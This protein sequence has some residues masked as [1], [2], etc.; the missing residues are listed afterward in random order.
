MAIKF[1]SNIRVGNF[2]FPTVDGTAGQVLGTDGNGNL[3]FMSAATAD[4]Y[5]NGLTFSSGTLTASVAGGSDV[6][7]SLDGRYALTSHNH[8]GVYDNYQFWNLK[9]NGTQ[10]TTVQSGG[11]LD[12]V[13]GSNVSLSYSAGGVVTISSTDTDTNYY[14]TSA[15]FNTS[16]GI[17]T[18]TRNDGGTVTVDL[19]GKY[20]ESS[21]THSN[22]TQS[23]AGFMSA[24][25]KT[26]LDGIAT[27]ATANTGTVTSVSGTGSVSG[28]TL[29]GTVTTSGSLTLGGT[30]V[31]TSGQVT[32]ALGYTPYQ[33]GTALDASTITLPQNP[34]G[35]T[36]GNGVASAPA[37]Y[38]GQAAGGDD[39]WKLY[40][41]SSAANSVSMVFEV[42]DDIEVAG[43][44]WIFRNKKTYGDYAATTPFRISGAGAA[45]INGNIVYHAGNFT[46]N[47]SNWN[48]AYS[49]GNHATAGYLTSVTNIS[50]NAGTATTLQTARSINGTAFNG[51]ADITTSFW[52]STRTITIGST[53]KSVNGSGNVSWTLAEIGAPSTTGTGASGTWPIS[54]SG[55]ADTVDGYHASS[56]WRSDGGTWNPTANIALNQTAN[57]QEWSFDIT[58]NGYTGGY[59][60]VWDSTN[61]TMLKVDAVTGKVSAPYN[62]VGNLEGNASTSTNAGYANSAGTAGSVTG[63]TLN[64]SGNPI[65]PDNVTQNQLGYNTNVSL[66]GQTDGGLYS[67]AYSSSWIH[68]IYGD[69]RSGQIAVR[70]KNNGSWQPWRTVLDSS[71]F[72]SWAQPAG[73][74]AAASHTHTPSQVGLGNVTNDTQV[75]VTYNTT[76][77]SDTR[78]RR[79]VTRLFR[80]DDDSDFSVQTYWTGSY[81]RLYGYYGDDGHADT[82]VGYADS[83]GYSS[84]TGS[85]A[86]TNVSGRPTNVS[87]FTNDS[88][89]VTAATNRWYDGWVTA[90]GY[91]ADT[92]AGSKSGFTYA[93]NAPYNGPLA[94]IEAGGYGLQL[95]ASYGGGG[96]QIGYRTRNGDAGTW[97]SWRELMHSGNIGSQSVN[98]ASSA[99]SVAWG[100]VSSKPS[101]L[102]YWDT[103]YGSSYLGSDGN[104]YMGWAGAWLSTWLNQSVRTDADP[105]FR[106]VY[107]TGWFRNY[108]QQGIYNQDYGTHFYSVG[109]GVWGITGSGSGVELQFRAN[110]QSTIRGYVYGDTSNNFGF[111]NDQGGWAVRCYSGSGYGGALTGTWTA[112]GDLVA[113]SDARVKEN[114]KTIDNALDK[115][116][117]LRGVEYNRTDSKD[118]SK[119]VGVIAQEIKEVLPEV[120]FEQEDGM[121]GVSYGNIV[122]VLIEAIKEQQKQIEELKAKLK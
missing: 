49:W 91:N 98:Y 104:L 106:N 67:S 85:V 6:S 93:Y 61:S 84:S 89:Y 37:Y 28:L 118:K 43:S 101:N 18:L 65:N 51:S 111:L 110:H 120:V 56:L 66:F 94:H 72:S 105:T 71:N 35:T 76:L 99:G 12:L 7:V 23:V 54:I 36:Y 57:N 103:W 44:E 60:H 48:T 14:V 15:S 59:W 109:S 50:G 58:R 30:L 9:T 32:S 75:A 100:N 38:I 25:D 19:D 121:L 45:Y 92:I 10:R 16:N 70:G 78:N 53:G 62:F 26:K 87:S 21:H 42:N 64:S 115:V 5:I 117:S 81:W 39:A 41:E 34:T 79:G 33:E 119:K 3:T 1:L 108:G 22:A 2:L 68:Q 69:F 122:G 8:A 82:H 52:G 47:S 63:L 86:W 40:G 90:P 114:I 88:G 11:V 102:T 96:A 4:K 113:Y 29:S 13:A 112:S 80:R 31:L 83:S 107:A 95:N 20:A 55:N 74:Y 17:L 77:N 27:G 73:S 46:D 97:N 116:L 24:A